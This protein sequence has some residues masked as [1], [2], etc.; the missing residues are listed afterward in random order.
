MP[1]VEAWAIEPL[2]VQFEALLPPHLETHPWG[3]HNPRIPDRIVFDKLVAK[4]VFG[5]SYAKHA[6]Q[7]CPVTEDGAS[8]P[9]AAVHRSPH[10]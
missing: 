2:L 1:A 8:H 4:L 7:S 5:G 9:I 6:D 10:G 3:C